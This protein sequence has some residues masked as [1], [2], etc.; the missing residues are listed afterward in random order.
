MVLHTNVRIG[1]RGFV[2][3]NA[4]AYLNG[5][6]VATKISFITSTPLA[7]VFLFYKAN[8]PLREINVSKK[9]SQKKKFKSFLLFIIS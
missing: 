7:L 8:I 1:Y 3:T 2:G 5:S 9:N 4:S 6:T